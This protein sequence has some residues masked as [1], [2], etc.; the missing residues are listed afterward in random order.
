M[1]INKN[2]CFIHI[3]KAGGSTIENIILDYETNYFY[4]ILLKI[5]E[6]LY[7]II[8][9]YAS[10]LCSIFMNY[11]L[12]I[13]RTIN[14]WFL[15]SYHETYLSKL[16]KE[17]SCNTDKRMIY[18]SC[19]RHPQARLVSLY[20]FLQ[21]SIDFDTFVINLLSNKYSYPPLISY[22]EQSLFLC[23]ENN[24]IIVPYIKIE[25]INNDW[26]K[27]CK[28]INIPY[29]EN[30]KENNGICNNIPYKNKSYPMNNNLLHWKK[31]YDKY[32][33]LVDIVKNYYKNDFINFN[34]DI[35]YP[36]KNLN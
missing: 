36:I 3:P 30:G 20:T 29:K 24:N 35:Y 6:F 14:D 21:P 8:K 13:L 25:N 5:S 26:K 28:L 22:Q 1:I 32:P 15:D 27:I 18:F 2:I 23:D 12:Q 17:Y 33:Y 31:Y 19:V 11:D 10:L 4:Y 9:K 34:Y 7:D 16:K